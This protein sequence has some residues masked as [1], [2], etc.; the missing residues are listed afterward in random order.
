MT[1]YWVSIKSE[2]EAYYKVLEMKILLYENRDIKTKDLIKSLNRKLLG[3]YHYYGVSNT[4]S[5]LRSYNWVGLNE[6][7]K[8][9]KIEIP[10][11]YVSLFE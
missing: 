8:V 10:K 3:Y 5:N 4:K 2:A 9:Y 6:M 1:L 11:I 7:F